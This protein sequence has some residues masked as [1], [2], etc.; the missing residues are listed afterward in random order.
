MV[1]DEGCTDG[2]N[3]YSLS[4]C[5]FHIVFKALLSGGGSILGA[6]CTDCAGGPGRYRLGL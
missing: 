3:I 2:K 4:F 5:F 1:R 6:G